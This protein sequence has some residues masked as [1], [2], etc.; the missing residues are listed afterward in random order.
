MMEVPLNDNLMYKS[1]SIILNDITLFVG[2]NGSGKSHNLQ[3]IVKFLSTGISHPNVTFINE[4][5]RMQKNQGMYSLAGYSKNPLDPNWG[6]YKF[7][8]EMKPVMDI[9][10]DLFGREIVIETVELEPTN[11]FYKKNNKLVHI[12]EDGL[13]IS[14][15]VMI[16]EALQ[17]MP[18]NSYLLVDELTL[19][20]HPSL[21]P[22]YITYLKKYVDDKHIK[23]IATTQDLSCLLYFLANMNDNKFSVYETTDEED[24]LWITPIEASSITSRLRQ[25]LGVI[26]SKPYLDI[27]AELGE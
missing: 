8:N 26:A 6:N 12:R 11:V 1:T 7:V 9:V 18:E 4:Q 22:K 15:T 21:I 16:F 13:G 19:G 25:F 17:Y 23:I 14:N 27:L 5:T 10:S 2:K 24:G 20:L 3:Q